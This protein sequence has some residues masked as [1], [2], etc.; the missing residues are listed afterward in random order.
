M[1]NTR[2]KRIKKEDRELFRQTVGT[3][4]PVVSNRLHL[5]SQKKPKP[6]PNPRQIEFEARPRGGSDDL[7]ELSV[8]DSLSYVTPAL[9]KNILKKMRRGFFD[10]E[11]EL[12]LHGFTE[13]EAR[14]QLLCFI[15]LCVL[16]GLRCVHIIHGKG[17]RSLQRN[18]LLK[19]KVNLWL[20]QH[21]D[22]LAFCSAKPADGGTGAIY[23]LLRK[24]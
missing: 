5:R 2:N 10:I 16:D 6:M 1:P 18:P 13:R 19:N 15:H 7:A 9:Q 17:Y 24:K 3:V 4:S 23:A 14:R 12:D 21:D 11:A 20:R 22:I 8:T